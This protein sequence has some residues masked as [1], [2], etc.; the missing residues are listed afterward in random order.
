MN[1]LDL[2]GNTPLLEI[3]LD[4]T[5]PQKRARVFAKAEYFNPSGSVKD[6]AAK[7]MLMTAIADGS[8]T[9]GKIILDST[10]GNT[11]IAY[12]MLGAALGYAVELCMPA[13]ASMERKKILRVYGAQIIE[14]DPLESSDG[15]YL[16]AK[17]LAE[18]EPQKYFFPDQYNN[19]ANWQA[20]YNGTAEE[21]LRQFKDIAPLTHFL[22]G[23]GTSGTFTGTAKKLKEH[24]V[25]AILMQP[26]SP[27]HGLEGMKHMESTIKPAFFDIGLA[28]E[29]VTVGTEEA[30]ETT[31]RLAR[32]AGIFVGVSTGANVYAALELAKRLPPTAVIVT[33][34]CDNGFRY[35]TEPV[36]G[37]L[38]A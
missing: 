29:V 12:A 28:D 32:E 6:R 23:A 5:E 25:K 30:Y 34:L 19:D 33:I 21:I 17:E 36:F 20:H 15:A 27:F 3:T 22:A 35:L 38:E 7:N 13:N 18:K 9:K 8:L 31:R 1:T 4:K 26:D 16:L 2:V 10:S 11:G 14:T 24:G 37:G